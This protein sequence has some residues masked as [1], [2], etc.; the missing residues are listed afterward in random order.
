MRSTL[1]ASAII[2]LLFTCVVSAKTE[3]APTQ[4]AQSHSCSER[5]DQQGLSGDARKAFQTTCTKGSLAPGQPTQPAPQSAAAKAL[6][7]PSGVDRTVRSKQC[8]EQAAKRGLHDSPLQAFRKSCLAS[9]A[10]VSAVGSKDRPPRP[11]RA[12]PKLEALT[13]TPPR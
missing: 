5:A 11:T 10:P 1:P 13:D 3:A 12:K 4:S 7:Q 6:T 8:D 9:A 2:T